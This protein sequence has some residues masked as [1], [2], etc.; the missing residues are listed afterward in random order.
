RRTAR[1]MGASQSSQA[2]TSPQ[3]DAPALVLARGALAGIAT[4]MALQLKSDPDLW[5]HLRLGLDFWSTLTVPTSDVY[6]FTSDS[7]WINHEWLWDVLIAPIYQ[8]AG[9][10]GL[11]MFTAAIVLAAIAVARWSFS[12]ANVGGWAAEILTA[13]VLL[14]GVAPLTQTLRAQAFSSLLFVVLLT[15]MREFD[16]SH[17]R[18]VLAAFPLLFL[19]WANIHGA[20]V[21]GGA[22]LAIWIAF[23]TIGL[24]TLRE[25]VLLV[26]AG[27]AA[28]TA[29]FVN[30][31]GIELWRFLI[32]TVR[33]ERSDIIEW[34]SVLSR[35]AMLL[36][37]AIT[38]AI[39]IAAATRARRTEAPYVV[40]CLFLAVSSFQVIRVV[41]FFSIAVLLL[42]APLL[43]TPAAGRVQV[44]FRE[45]GAATMIWAV[46]VA[47]ASVGEARVG[48]LRASDN[49]RIDEQAAQFLRDN[50][51]A[52]RLLVWFDW[53]EYVSWHFGSTLKVSMDG[54]R[55]TVY[56][57]T[58]IAAH[59][60][61][62]RNGPG[63][64]A[65]IQRLEPD[66][67]WLPKSLPV[68]ASIADWGW[69]PVF[70]T[71]T[72]I[73]WARTNRPDWRFP[74]SVDNGCFPSA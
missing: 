70:Q 63:A 39:A 71:S 43:V 13:G 44:S 29:T 31:Y 68:S 37:W 19:A 46:C 36:P 6:S 64:R 34:G 57:A 40:I 52:G 45:V 72:S 30:P 10:A 5:G 58:F 73:V 26:G 12:R 2:T 14:L 41:P 55:E 18:R 66:F 33:Y 61:F 4:A 60:E 67:V 22:V 16:R 24:G 35:P 28:A 38:A 9:A 7:A 53:G 20:W 47:S 59:N 48:C 1:A 74:A 23:R 56:S 17:S 69:T 15:L 62:Y 3:R 27:V 51:A 8:F 32:E 54:R 65:F 25:R 21:M 42:L 50:R 49:L 11:A